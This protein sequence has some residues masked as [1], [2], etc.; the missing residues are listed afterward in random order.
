MASPAGRQRPLPPILAPHERRRHKHH[1]GQST[2][3]KKCSVVIQIFGSVVEGEEKSRRL[4]G[5]GGERAS[6]GD[7]PRSA[8]YRLESGGQ[9]RVELGRQRVGTDP[10]S[11][12]QRS[13][14]DA[15]IDKN[16]Y[17]AVGSLIG[18]SRLGS[19]G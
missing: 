1:P 6:A 5:D 12:Q 4:A 18:P 10:G 9:Y 2:L 19:T 16:R 7:Q 3:Q 15:V 8:G 17:P 14:T 11:A 13:P